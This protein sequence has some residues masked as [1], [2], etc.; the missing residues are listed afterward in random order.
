MKAEEKRAD[1]TATTQHTGWQRATLGELLPIKYGKSL[2]E[3]FRD[4]TGR[5][6]VFGSSGQVGMHSSALTTGPTLIIGRKGNVGAIHYSSEPCWPIDTVYYVEPDNGQNLRYY[7]YLLNSLNLVKLDKSTA[8]PGL[9][10]DDYN[11]V[12]IV[13]APL[14]QQ[15]RIV[16]EIEKQFSRLDEAV[17]NLKRVKANLKRYKAAVLKAAVEGKLTEAWRKQH[18]PSPAGGRGAGGEGYEPASELL[19]RIL[20]ERRTKWEQA[21]L[22]KMQAKGKTPKD[23]TWKKKYPEPAAPDTTNLP[24]LPKGWVWASVLQVSEQIVDCP[25]STAK[26]VQDGRP[27]IDTTCI[28]PG[29]VLYEKLRF[30]SEET[31]LERIARL[32][33]QLGDI[34]FAREGT[35][36]TAVVIPAGLAP[37]LGQ[38][39]MLMRVDRCTSPEFLAFALESAVVRAQYSN[40]ILGSTVPH[41][42]VADVKALGIPLPPLEEQQ[43][44]V[45]EVSRYLSIVAEAEAQVNANLQRAERLRQAVLQSA[46]MS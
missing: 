19:Q 3:K 13:V 41:L 15:K 46:F 2:P 24:E 39:V 28:A 37:C 11:A 44:I 22:A 42:N 38:R 45:A 31:Y 40:K 26:F 30:V 5:H 8:V 36:G 17:A 33:P 32:K 7:K 34:I 9:S 10:R 20:A 1:Y 16:A 21:E 29:R 23:D 35:V 14:N 27:C 4:I 6:P 12:K 43:V 25:H 18:L